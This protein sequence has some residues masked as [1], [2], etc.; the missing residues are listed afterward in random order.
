MKRILIYRHPHCERCARIA[1]LHHAVD[2]L[3]RIAD[4]TATPPTGP[5]RMGEIV[6][7][8]LATRR[9]YRGAE[10]VGVVYRQVILYWPLLLLLWIPPARAW[11]DRQV[12]GCADG[13]CQ[14]APAGDST[15]ASPA[16]HG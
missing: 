8:E 16:H 15:G 11:L 3:D 9:I 10:A 7:E 5:L 4:T 1:R 13:S 6:V 12:R 2:W 14:V